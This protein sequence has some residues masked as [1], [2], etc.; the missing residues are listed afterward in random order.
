MRALGIRKQTT[1]IASAIVAVALLLGGVVLVLT[2]RLQLEDRLEQQAETRAETL[3]EVVG[4]SGPTG[5]GAPD[6]DD[7][8]EEDGV[9]EVRDEDD[10]L[11]HTTAPGLDPRSDGFVVESADAE[12]QGRDLTV[13]VGVSREDVDDATGALLVPLLAGIPV[14]LFVVA[15]TTWLVV[16]RT[17]RPVERIRSEVAG[18][19]DD[20][21]D[22]RV[23][24]PGTGDEIDRLATTMNQM[25]ERL[26]RSRDQ[27]RRF[28]SDASHE[29]RTPIATLRQSAE[30]ATV[31]ADAFEP[32]EFTEMVAEE[33]QRMQRLVEQLL[34]LARSD[35]SSPEASEDVDVDDVVLR[36]AARLTSLGLE[37]DT[38]AITPVRTRGSTVAWSQM[39]R[40]LTDNAA[41]HAAGRVAYSVRLEHGSVVVCVDDDGTGVPEADREDRKSVV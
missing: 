33:S 9:V 23:P 2:V 34:V 32:G 27:Q 24:E 3:A 30:V 5:V 1:L 25:L 22:R 36:E 11:L 21:L 18:I 13:V 40:N 15:G 35:G 4:T 16:G 12:W 26:E 6:D 14:L 38:S 17:L 31:H 7:L 8:D 20:R 10:S 39:V 37:V 28:V 19:T 29:L 41:R